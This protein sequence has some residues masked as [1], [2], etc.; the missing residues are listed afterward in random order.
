MISW[1]LLKSPSASAWRKS[2]QF[3]AGAGDTRISPIPSRAFAKR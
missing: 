2:N 3:T 1:A